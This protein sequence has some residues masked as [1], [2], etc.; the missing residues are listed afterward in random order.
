M[1]YTYRIA[2]D[3][4][5]EV[6]QNDGS[7]VRP[8]LTGG[9]LALFRKNM[10]QWT[11]PLRW[12]ERRTGVPAAYGAGVIFGESGG[13]P[14]KQGPASDHGLGLTMITAQSLKQGLSDAEVMEPETNIRLGFDFLKTIQNKT[15]ID[16][17]KMASSYNAGLGPHPSPDAPWGWREYRLP[18]GRQPYISRV[19]AAANTALDELG[20]GSTGWGIP[21]IGAAVGIVLGIAGGIGAALAGSR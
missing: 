4:G 12:N 13:D 21:M 3:H 5:V 7:W 11:E 9:E 18:D 6:L 16:L 10:P 17:P 14:T 8:V 19:V 20:P 1:A 15:G 2:D